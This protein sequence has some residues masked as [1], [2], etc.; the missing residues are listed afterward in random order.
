MAELHLKKQFGQNFIQSSEVIE[1]I[2]HAF[3][4]GDKDFVIEIGPGA[5]ALTIPLS[6]EVGHLSAIEI[7]PTVKSA[8]MN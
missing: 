1:D 5:G 2:I 3:R 8:S 6:G 7:D 4:P